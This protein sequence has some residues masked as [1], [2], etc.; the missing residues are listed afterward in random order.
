MKTYLTLF[1]IVQTLFLFSIRTQDIKLPVSLPEGHPRLLI[2]N[3]GKE[4]LKKLITTENW[5]QNTYR[6]ALIKYKDTL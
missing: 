3:E 1:F 4:S 6:Q 2:R 5:A